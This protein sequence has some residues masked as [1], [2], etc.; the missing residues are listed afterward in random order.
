MY[1]R[2]LRGFEKVM[3]PQNFRKCRPVINSM[4][5][6][7]FFLLNQGEIVA[8]GNTIKALLW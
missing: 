6:L 3:E 8:A 7:G 5:G 1:L 2:A 4:L